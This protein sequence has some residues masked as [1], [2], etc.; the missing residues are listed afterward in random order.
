MAC[1]G[2]KRFTTLSLILATGA[3]FLLGLE[4]NLDQKD[5][6]PVDPSETGMRRAIDTIVML[7]DNAILGYM[8]ILISIALLTIASLE[9]VLSGTENKLLRTKFVNASNLHLFVESTFMVYAIVQFAHI[10]GPIIG[11]MLNTELGMAKSCQMMGWIG[12]FAIFLYLGFALWVHCTLYEENTISLT[13]LDIDDDE[14]IE[15]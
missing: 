9:E 11:G 15:N 10:I 6:D 12:A 5:K 4:A 8:L 2:P 14:P 1:T 7:A 13:D 3:C